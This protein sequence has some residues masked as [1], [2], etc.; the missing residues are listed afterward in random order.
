M[1]IKRKAVYEAAR[2]RN[3]KRWTGTTRNWDGILAVHLNPDK[4]ETNN[5][6]NT[7]EI[8]QNKKAA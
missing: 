8:T 2:D 3:P 5:K 4:P 7:E 6:S 1:L